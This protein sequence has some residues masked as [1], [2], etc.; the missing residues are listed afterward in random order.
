[1]FKARLLN[2]VGI[3]VVGNLFQGFSCEWW[4]NKHNTHHAIPNLHESVPGLH[5]GDP[6]IDTLPF[7][8]WSLKMLHKITKGGPDSNMFSRFCVRNQ[9][10]LYFPILF[11]ARIVWALQ[12]LSFA[13]QMEN[14]MFANSEIAVART[15][16]KAIKGVT[17]Y[18]LRYDFSEKALLVAHYAWVAALTLGGCN[19]SLGRAALFFVVSETMCG[20][21]L[22]IAF[23][24]GHNGMP[25]F[26][27][28][29]KPEFAALQVRTTRN[30]D[31]DALGFVGWFMGGLHYQIE[32]H[33]FP[34]VPRHNL[35]RIAP[36]LKDLCKKHNVPYHSTTLFQ[37]SV[38]ILQ[39]LSSLTEAIEHF[40][41]Q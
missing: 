10:V 14:G 6:D 35:H 34:M 29:Q 30:V 9:A 18:R 20:L 2:D 11:F 41:G 23:G 37:G 27:K 15:A 32:H 16:A 7:L 39:H 19:G 25:T 13:F 8:A 24:V 28:D 40:P 1:V 17:K 3:L 26:D 22:A 5:D 21:L 4:K 36:R 33:L 31:N 38:E 12:S